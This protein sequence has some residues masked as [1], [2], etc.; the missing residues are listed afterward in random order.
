MKRQRPSY[1][2]H[3]LSHSS[4]VIYPT[5]TES[6]R[7]YP[8]PQVFKYLRTLSVSRKIS[9]VTEVPKKNLLIFTGGWIEIWNNK[10][11]K[12][13]KKF[14]SSQCSSPRL[15]ND[16]ILIGIST[17]KQPPCFLFLKVDTAK[18]DVIHL[19]TTWEGKISGSVRSFDYVGTEQEEK[20]YYAAYE[21]KIHVYD[22]KTR[23]NKLLCELQGGGGGLVSLKID[24]ERVIVA[25]TSGADRIM[26][27]IVSRETGVCL[28]NFT[29]SQNISFEN[30]LL[31]NYS[32]INLEPI[33]FFLQWKYK[34][35]LAC[36]WAFPITDT[37]MDVWL[38]CPTERKDLEELF[39]ITLLSN[40]NMSFGA[41]LD[42]LRR[43]EW[44]I[45]PM[46]KNQVLLNLYLPER[47]CQRKVGILRFHSSKSM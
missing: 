29:V 44:Y 26:I 36:R 46:K 18:L 30:S 24:N 40:G 32:F 27:R 23:K 1:C 31:S 28:L 41:V 11:L 38:D 21:N 10:T 25:A 42:Q 20:I 37:L 34:K 47:G 16:N 39:S 13:I 2:S 22:L 4:H 14:S 6:T 9:S 12:C 33:R 3:Q 19:L 45:I 5:C 8:Y 15:F 35:E 7:P 43:A 17:Q